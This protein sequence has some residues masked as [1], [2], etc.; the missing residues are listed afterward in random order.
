MSD[1]GVGE[2]SATCV[3]ISVAVVV[4]VAVTVEV[5]KEVCEGVG[6]LKISPRPKCDRAD[7]G[8]GGRRVGRSEGGESGGGVIT[9]VAR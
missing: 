8:V 1:V 6:V 3:G 9:C 4:A 5:A 2:E 7:V